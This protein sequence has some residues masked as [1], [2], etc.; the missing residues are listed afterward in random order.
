[1]KAAVVR[2]KGGPFL[3]EDANVDEPR[4]DEVLV[5]IK[6]AGICHSDI[7][8]RDQIFPALLPQVFG[9][10]GAGIVEKVGASVTQL[11]K[12]DH[13]LLTFD[14]CGEC[15]SCESNLHPY[16]DHFDVLNASGGRQ[17]GSTAL[18]GDQVFLVKAVL[19]NTPLLKKVT[20]YP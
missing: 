18:S 11:K 10:E 5:K 9:H 14:S 8:C 16:C 19:P 2:Q 4:D 12:G 7:S 1:M 15:S 6:A 20:L 13:V 17:D 3:I